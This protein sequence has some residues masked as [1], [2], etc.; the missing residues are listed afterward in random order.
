MVEAPTLMG[1]NGNPLTA[2]HQSMLWQGLQPYAWAPPA[3]A[4]P[5]IYAMGAARGKTLLELSPQ[6]VAA[7]DARA[8]TRPARSPPQL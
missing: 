4:T 6:E 7:L 5:F 8:G 2:P 1:P 3:L